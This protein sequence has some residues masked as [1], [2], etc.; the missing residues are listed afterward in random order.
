M[1]SLFSNVQ[2]KQ[3]VHPKKH[4]FFYIFTSSTSFIIKLFHRIKHR[5][6]ILRRNIR[7]YIVHG[8][9]D[10]TTS[11]RH[12]LQTLQDL[13]TNLSRCAVVQ[14]A[15]GFYTTA[16]ESTILSELFTALVCTGLKTSIPASIIWGI[17]EEIEPQEWIKV[18][19]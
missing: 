3:K 1:L 19:I 13:F 10:K 8:I 2:V 7:K 9:K 11:G 17:N 5:D 4:C 12:D 18:C 15:D 6:N 16:P 14:C